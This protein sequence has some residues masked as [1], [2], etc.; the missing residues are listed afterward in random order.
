MSMNL[1]CLQ[2]S[3]KPTFGCTVQKLITRTSVPRYLQEPVERLFN[4]PFDVVH[5]SESIREGNISETQSVSIK[6]IPNKMWLGFII[7]FSVKP[8]KSFVPTVIV[9]LGAY[10]ISWFLLWV[11]QRM[12]KPVAS[13]E[14]LQL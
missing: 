8:R 4:P 7:K 12:S 6:V 2:P 9:K 13:T 11:R 14:R 3:S 1:S 10:L 5:S